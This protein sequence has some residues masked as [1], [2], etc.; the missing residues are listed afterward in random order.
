MGR[1]LIPTIALSFCAITTWASDSIDISDNL[2]EKELFDEQ[3]ASTLT[4]APQTK[5][6]KQET[7][8]SFD[9]EFLDL[10]SDTPSQEKSAKKT[11]DQSIPSD[12][13]INNQQSPVYTSQPV[14]AQAMPVQSTSST[15]QDYKIKSYYAFPDKEVRIYAAIDYLYW[16]VSEPGMFYATTTQTQYPGEPPVNFPVGSSGAYVSGQLGKI[17]KQTLGWSSGV[18]GTLGYQFKNTLWNL[19]AD[20]TY[21]N[22][23]NEIKL[24][25]PNSPYGYISGMSMAQVTKIMVQQSESK[26]EFNYQNAKVLLGTPWRDFKPGRVQ[27]LFGVHS[28]WIEQNWHVNFYPYID[29]SFPS[30]I[31]YNSRHNSSWGIGLN[32]MGKFDANL[33]KGF[34]FGVNGF[35]SGLIGQQSLKAKAYTDPILGP[36]PYYGSNYYQSPSYQFMSQL[37][38]SPQIAW[39]RILKKAAVRIEAAYEFN[40]LLN[41]LDLYRDMNSYEDPQSGKNPVMQNNSLYLHG[42]TV[43]FSA[44]F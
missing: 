12:A 33:G 10:F 8:S 32:A 18:R 35:V 3:P 24:D 17:Q 26:T 31:Q 14:Q 43:R 1:F 4:S 16:T 28:T 27:L 25:R 6:T 23:S 5:N 29:P 22:T 2:N 34:S 21:F 38:L 40:A 44:G 39:S 13:S 41:M 20:Y 19:T 9:K 7:L 42:L 30:Q 36:N 11:S 37:M 15:S